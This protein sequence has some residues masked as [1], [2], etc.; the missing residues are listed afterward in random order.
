MKKT[1]KVVLD[2]HP[3]FVSWK[4]IRHLMHRTLSDN[5]ILKDV[6]KGAIFRRVVSVK[7]VEDE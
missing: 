3:D 4:Q 7:V 5:L 1:F 6:Q 2:L